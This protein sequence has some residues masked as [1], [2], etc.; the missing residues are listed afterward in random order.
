M[1]NEGQYAAEQH[2]WKKV[3]RPAKLAQAWEK[4]AQKNL[5]CYLT[6]EQYATEYAAFGQHCRRWE[7]YRRISRA[8]ATIRL[9]RKQRREIWKVFE[10]YR[11]EMDEIRRI[12]RIFQ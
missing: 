1:N 9:N 4:A 11:T 8:G 6:A 3:Q 12:D 7:D 2:L 10:A 5:E